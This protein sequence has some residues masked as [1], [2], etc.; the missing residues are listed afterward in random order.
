MQLRDE[1]LGRHERADFTSNTYRDWML[2]HAILL[3]AAQAFVAQLH[4]SF[5]E[6]PPRQEAATFGINQA[7][8]ELRALPV[9]GHGTTGGGTHATCRGAGPSGTRGNGFR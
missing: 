7:L 5:L 1:R 3:V 2:D 6:F 8:D 9:R 4:A